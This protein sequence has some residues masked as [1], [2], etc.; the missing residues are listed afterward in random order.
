MLGFRSEFRS[1]VERA[2]AVIEFGIDGSI[3]YANA[4]FLESAGY[5]LA[6][7]IGKHHSI[8]VSKEYKQS[9]EYERFWDDLAKG[10][11]FA[12][13]YRRFRK[14]GSEFWISGSYNPVIRRGRVQKIVKIARDITA[15]KIER[16]HDK[17][18]LAAL[19]R[20]QAIVEFAL[21]GTVIAANQNFLTAFGYSREEVNGKH[22]QMFVDPVEAKSLAYQ[23][24]WQKLRS[25]EFEAAEYQRVAKG[26]RAVWIQASYNP[27]FDASGRVIGI[28]KF[29]TDITQAKDLAR[30]LQAQS[31]RLL[32]QAVADIAGSVSDI[33]SQAGS[34]AEAVA[35]ASDNIR[36]VAAGSTQIAASASEI[37][38]K[39]TRA[40]AVS[41]EAVRE[42]SL[43]DTLV[44]GLAENARQIG[45][46]VDLIASIAAQTN[47][48]ALNAAIEAARAGDAGKGFAVVADEVKKLAG[49]TESAANDIAARITSVQGASGR[50]CEAIRQIGQT[51]E[52]IHVAA[53]DI[54]NEV[55][56]QSAVTHT[57]SSSML[58][59]AT[60]IELIG[61]TL[62]NS[63]RLT[64][65]VD[66]RIQDI[67]RTAKSVT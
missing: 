47:L 28:I 24:F 14:D 31:D 62:S 66:Q 50:A 41:S 61:A 25:G 55:A 4:A 49:Q 33:N 12:S 8:L 11:G 57:M 35:N 64:Q 26:G 15:K 48:L 19:D 58:E 5:D 2:N 7:L 10:I 32:G 46:I 63:A 36:A 45:S 30:R 56:A 18:S 13:E 27:L 34:A 38:M 9:P 42:A 23:A 39:L 53:T 6:D 54:T 59:M 3:L 37:S 60:G 29:A 52:H 17:S 21:D 16:A 65:L 44:V 51:I 43:V 1:A 67:Q 20:S 40:L 22:H